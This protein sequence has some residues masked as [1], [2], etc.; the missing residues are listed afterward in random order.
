[1]QVST[2][3][4]ASFEPSFVQDLAL[5][6]ATPVALLSANDKPQILKISAID[7]LL[8]SCGLTSEAPLILW[9]GCALSL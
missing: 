4:R 5:V 8:Q 7:N 6:C 1:M 9:L 3:T 2:F